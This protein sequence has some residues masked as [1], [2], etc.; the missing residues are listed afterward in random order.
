LPVPVR[1]RY[2]DTPGGQVHLR[3]A[4]SAGPRPPLL[5][6]HM[7]PASGLVY[8]TLLGEIGTDRLAIAPDTPGFG[9]S[10]PPPAFPEIADYACAMRDTL[11]AL[12]I[13][14]PVDVMGY[15]TGGKTAVEMASLFPGL[16]RRIVMVSALIPTAEELARFRAL[17]KPGPI[18]TADGQRLL[19]TWLWFQAF[20]GVGK[21]N[22]LEAAARIFYERLSGRDRHFWGH[23]AAFNYEAGPKIA[24]LDIPILLLNPDDDLRQHT[25]RAAPLLRRG[26]MVDL[27]WTHGW[28]DTHAATG[29][30]L[31][32]DFLDSP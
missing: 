13:E 19:D 21:A 10:D 28:M 3:I 4:G 16:V 5:C 20:F 14:G 8:E 23:R 6:L 32:R 31:I 18:L 15:H 17:Y 22:T 27:D 12:G 26:R 7:S 24:A 1:R 11:A 30:A 29:A 25:P 2:A 9:N